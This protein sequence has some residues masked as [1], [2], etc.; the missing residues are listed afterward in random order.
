MLKLAKYLLFI[1][2]FTFFIAFNTFAVIV[3]GIACKVNDSIITIHEFEKAYESAVRRSALLGTKTP[4]KREIMDRLVTNLLIKEEAEKRGIVVT[5]NEINEIID[6]LKKENNLSDKAFREEL[7]REGMTLDELKENYRIGILKE[8]LINQ[9]I[10]DKGYDVSEDE[11]EKFYRDPRNRKLFVLPEIVK[12]SEIFISV[13]ADLDFKGQI[14]LKEKVNRI[15]EEAKDGEDFQTLIEKYSEDPRKGE[16]RGHIGS[17]NKR[18]LSMWLSPEDVELI[19]SY[20]RG[21]IVPP[22]RTREGYYIFRIDDKKENRILSLKEAHDQIK[23]Y[24]LKKKGSELFNKWLSEKKKK[25][26][27]QYMIEME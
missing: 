18:Q 14:E 3:N 1:F 10:S 8:R 7:K 6:K 4:S 19:F 2:I 20:N 12:L 26:F 21:D 16:N 9:M 24:L 25:S 13:P 11:I 5:D 17:F 23:S 22:I 15:Y 27:I